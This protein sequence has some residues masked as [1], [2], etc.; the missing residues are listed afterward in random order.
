MDAQLAAGPDGGA[1]IGPNAIIR[2]AEA[3]AELS[4]AHRTPVFAAAGLEHYLE[5]LPERMVPEADVSALQAA[6]GEHL[7][8]AL[9]DSIN[10]RAGQLTADYLLANRIPR[11]VQH[12]LKPL[13][14][15]LAARVLLG[16]IARHAW[17]FAG[18]GTFHAAPIRRGAQVSIVG[19]PVCAGR[20]L[21]HPACGYFTAT[22][23]GLFV[24]LVHPHSRVRETA[25]QAMG[26]PACR[27]D[28][29]W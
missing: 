24:S 25:C 18:S 8:P 10:Q 21:D 1:R 16:A 28:I 14:A 4:P 9:A 23:A 3:L 26:D 17:T 11:A 7:P 13:P 5:H 15:G 27:F 22:F 6:V 12:L 29:R 20:H 2:I 19:C